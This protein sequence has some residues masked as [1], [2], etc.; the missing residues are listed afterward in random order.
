MNRIVTCGPGLL[1]GIPT[2]GRP[3]SL[4]WAISFKSLVPPIN[5][6]QQTVIIQGRPIA[7]ARE[8]ICEDAVKRGIKYVF[9]LGDDV[10]APLHTL[11]QLIFRMEHDEKLGVVGGV[12]FSKCDPPAPLVFRENGG[13]SYWDWKVGEYFEVTG[14]GMDCT[15]IRTSILEKIKKPWFQTIDKD[16]FKDAVNQADMWTEDLYFLKKLIEETDYKVYCDASVIC[17]HQ[18][19][20]ENKDYT[21]PV[22]SLP[23][24]RLQ[25]VKTKKMIDIGCGPINRSEEFP[26]YDLVRVDIRDDCNPDF[27]C[28]VRD[29]PFPEKSFD[30]VFSSHVLEHFP[31]G[32]WKAVLKEWVRL[33]KD[34][35][36]L[37]LVLPNIEWAIEHY[38]DVGKETDVYNV[39][40]GAQ[41]NPFDYHYNGLTPRIMTEE[42]KVLGFKTINIDTSNYYN[43]IIS[44]SYKEADPVAIDKSKTKKFVKKTELKMNQIT[45]KLIQYSLPIEAEK[46]KKLVKKVKK[47][48][49]GIR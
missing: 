33:V 22:G 19:I 32:E 46:N 3:V 25:I 39:L 21:L 48:K 41:S 29:L 15:L 44:A 11:K 34:D 36:E 40:Y 4:N 23:T 10:V 28:D 27:R 12:Y 14:L 9:F 30:R 17:V 42:L 20:Y 35:G 37:L 26:E 2:L 24:R 8:L 43:M 6:N 18:D 38:K 7:E 49:K 45:T 16:S 1:I 47:T 5:F 13:G 31:R